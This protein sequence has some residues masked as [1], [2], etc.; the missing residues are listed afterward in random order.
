MHRLRRSLRRVGKGVTGG[1]GRIAETI[2]ATAR[3]HRLALLHGIEAAADD[4]GSHILAA[5]LTCGGWC[6]EADKGQGAQRGRGR[7]R[8]FQKL[9]HVALS[10]LNVVRCGTQSTFG[11]NGTAAVVALRA[12]GCSARKA[13]IGVQA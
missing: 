10:V 13:V 6:R 1:P 2:A 4:A 5:I 9:L 8:Q 12:H 3:R 7:C 11:L